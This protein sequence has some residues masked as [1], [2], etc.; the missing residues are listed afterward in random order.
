LR[1]RNNKSKMSEKRG[2]G[3]FEFHAIQARG[4]PL[5]RLRGRSRYGVAKARGERAGVR[6]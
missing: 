1:L 2:A 3:V 6:G 4:P 5:P